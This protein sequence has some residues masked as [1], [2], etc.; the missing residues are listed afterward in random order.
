MKIAID[1]PAGAGKS[2]IAK[3]IANKLGF[4]YID[5]GA[6]YRAL[7]WK[8]MQNGIDLNDSQALANLAKSTNINFQYISGEQRVICDGHDVSEV[9][10]SPEVSSAVS[11]VASQGQVREV[12][13]AMQQVMASH[14][15]VVMDGRDI[16]ERVLPDADY[17]FF[18]TASLDERVSR[19]KRE[20]A[21]RGYTL[22]EDALRRDIAERDRMDMERAVGAL[23]ILPDSIMIDTTGQS[24]QEVC[25][26]ILGLL[27]ED[28]HV[29]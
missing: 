18:L 22:D 16:G 26:R 3:L 20:L 4:T 19:R 28:G 7:T 27:K 14:L 23:K 10:R 9:I 25:A 8:A 24:I 5:T 17:K 15:H 29:L 12:M 6:M 1:G 11:A 2:T 21:G 13:V